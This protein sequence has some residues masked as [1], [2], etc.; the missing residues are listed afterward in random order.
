LQITFT[1]AVNHAATLSSSTLVIKHDGECTLSELLATHAFSTGINSNTHET[2]SELLNYYCQ[3]VS[4][5]NLDV[6]RSTTVVIAPVAYYYT[7][8]SSSLVVV[9]LVLITSCNVQERDDFIA[10]SPSPITC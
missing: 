2:S 4:L 6:S 9:K 10:K 1:E 3:F 7:T 8:T 5:I